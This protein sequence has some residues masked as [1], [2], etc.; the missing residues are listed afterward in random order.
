MTIMKHDPK[1]SNSSSLTRFKRY[2]KINYDV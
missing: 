2:D 1:S